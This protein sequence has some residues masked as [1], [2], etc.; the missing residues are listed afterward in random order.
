MNKFSTL[1]RLAGLSAFAVLGFGNAQAAS[2][3]YDM[4]LSSDDLL[5]ISNTGTPTGNIVSGGAIYATVTIDDEGV[6]GLINFTVSL[7][8]YWAGKEDS[9][10][11]IQSFG[12][13]VTDPEEVN[14]LTSSDIINL[15]SVGWIGE[16]DYTGPPGPVGF[17]Q[18]GWGKFDASVSTSS[19]ANRVSSLT[20]SIDN[21]YSVDE[22]SDYIAGSIEGLNGSHF[23]AV[24][25]AGF[26]D[27]NPLDPVDTCVGVPIDPNNPDCNA[28]TSM[29]TA[30][31]TAAVPVP[32]AVWL[33][34][35]A[36]GMLG[37]SRRKR[38]A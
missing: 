6:S 3:T 4:T 34:G 8:D 38:A 28:L 10:F 21:S 32:A 7:T 5:H 29:W 36:L 31:S 16:V 27:Q 1:V 30:G 18:N 35:S 37:W 33:F 12:F 19:A 15:P 11:G 14:G 25:I 13:N 24:H 23:F 2:V 22:I 26:T 9:G 17:A 20:F